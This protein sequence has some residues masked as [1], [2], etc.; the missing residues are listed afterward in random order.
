M[1]RVTK[2]S[3]EKIAKKSEIH[4]RSCSLRT[5]DME[6][7]KQVSQ[8]RQLLGDRGSPKQFPRYTSALLGN[9]AGA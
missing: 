8:Q 3:L 1:L 4:L 2:V 9:S 6:G 5:E 7:N